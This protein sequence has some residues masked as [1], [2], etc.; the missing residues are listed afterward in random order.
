MKIKTQIKEI[1]T[2]DQNLKGKANLL[3]DDCFLIRDIRIVNGKSGLFISFPARR[4]DD[5]FVDVCF[6][7]NA[8]FREEIKTL[9]LDEYKRTIEKQSKSFPVEA[10]CNDDKR[11]DK[12]V[13]TE[14]LAEYEQIP[15]DCEDINMTEDSETDNDEV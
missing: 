1:C 7:L 6:P 4:V 9:I 11:E 2:G 10:V 13:K 8:A 12:E 14:P 15:H 5:R 3:L